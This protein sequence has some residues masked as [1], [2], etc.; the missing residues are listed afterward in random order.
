MSSG[1]IFGI[2]F[3]KTG[4]TSLAAALRELGYRT[5][6]GAGPLRQALG[7]AEMMRLLRGHQLEPI[8]Q[9]AERHDGFADTPWFMLYRDLDRRFPGS[10]FIL[11]V[12]DEQRWLASV[13][14]Y[15]GDTESDLRAWIYG[16]ASPVGSEGQWLARYRR[17]VEE[18]QA[19]FSRRRDQLLV[20]DW[21]RGGGW[22]ELCRFLG[23][24]P[25]SQPF[26][27][28]TK[29]RT[30]RLDLRGA[31]VVL[32]HPRTGSSLVM[33]TLRLLGAE[34]IGSLEHP[35]L[36]MSANPRGFFEEPEVLRRGLYAA[37]VAQQ[38]SLLR[39]RAVKL[40]L[41]PLV[42]R[43]SDDEWTSLARATLLL[44]IRS[45]AEW[46]VATNVLLRTGATSAHRAAAMRAW[47]RN[48][49]VDVGYLAERICSPDFAGAA[50]ICLD[51]RDAV[52]DP[53]AYVETVAAAA[54]LSPTPSQLAQAAA[55]IDRS[56]Y[57]VR[58]DEVDEAQRMAQGVRPLDTI[59]TLLRSRD[60]LKWIRLRDALPT[61]VFPRESVQT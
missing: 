54:G 56:L 13:M 33:Q 37:A 51:Y 50:P 23:R 7:Q 16:A 10:R 26:P 19:Y 38:P 11:T 5:C 40:A 48:F 58:L 20:V 18:V 22:E 46:L 59:Y 2:G 31:I 35:R 61:W 57:R 3:H 43:G 21:E 42:Q 8:M 14:R 12:R 29:A 52:T 41:H 49:L 15:F 47:A 36:P 34:V 39:G 28:L 25:P 53:G 1:K 32:T 6:D 4:T 45:P 17:H 60:P 24:T 55:N 9:V 44:P 27:H 30:P